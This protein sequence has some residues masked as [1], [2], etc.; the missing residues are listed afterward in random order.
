MKIVCTQENLKTA[1]STVGRII[2]SS[3]TLPIL[4]NILI[5]TE[6]GVLKISSTNLEV[7]IV[8]QARCKVEEEGS[9]TVSSKTI[10]DLIGNMP[11][12][13]ISLFTE[14]SELK[15][16]TENY[17]TSIKTLPPEDFPLIPEVES[18]SV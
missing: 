11:N 15:V 4:S 6:N 8:T 9:V 12:K 3:N 14:G 13:N 16:D 1:L 5:K 18:G 2:S 10:T 7:A 17:H